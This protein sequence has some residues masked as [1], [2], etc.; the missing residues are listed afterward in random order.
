MKRG[1][2]LE[3]GAM[4]G[5]F[6]CGVTDVMMEQGL[7]FDGAMG[8]SAGAI[9]GC[10]YKS[11]QPGRAIRYNMRFCRDKRYGTIHSLLK[12]GDLYDADFCYR[13]IPDELDWFDTDAFA[14]NPMEFWVVATD[15]KT[16]KPVYHRCT[17]GK[18]EDVTW[19]R[20]SG[21]MPLAAKPVE[22]GGYTLLDGGVA[23]S[24]PL[25]KMEALGYDR[26]VVVLTQPMGYHKGKNKAL[27][28]M[29]LSLRQYPAFLRTAE[30]RPEVYNETLRKIREKER[31]GEIF[32]LRPEAALDIGKTE[33]DPERLQ[34][35][36]EQGRTVMEKRLAALQEFLKI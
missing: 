32:V 19:I 30:R 25:E 2:I 3:G 23:D 18:R 7:T 29:K 17:D 14:A 22:V 31:A 16:G 15:V 12:T 6:T 34:A 24:I 8:V 27:P 5:M 11:D 36:Y 13:Q 4:R 1:L 10:N 9:F 28:L 35:V 33:H 20:A 21:S 26:N